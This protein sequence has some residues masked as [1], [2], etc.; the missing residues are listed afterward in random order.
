MRALIQTF[1]EQKGELGQAL[2]QHIGISVLSL[3]IA[4]LIAMPLAIWATHHRKVAELL[5]QITGVLQTIPSLALLGLLIP[6]VG[7]GS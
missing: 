6:L 4:I 5:L 7:I 3:L 1:A 2:L